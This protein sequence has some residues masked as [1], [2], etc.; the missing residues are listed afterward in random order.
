MGEQY[1]LY[2]YLENQTSLFLAGLKL[3]LLTGRYI[4]GKNSWKPI[5]S[6]TKLCFVLNRTDRKGVE[7][8]NNADD[9]QN[10]NIPSKVKEYHCIEDYVEHIKKQ[11]KHCHNHQQQRR[12]K[13]WGINQH[14][15]N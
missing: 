12:Q 3:K 13:T 15:G 1:I 8:N 14:N 11:Q 2:P 5:L 10:L 4:S 6:T 7:T 9:K